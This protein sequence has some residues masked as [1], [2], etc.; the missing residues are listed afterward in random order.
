MRLAGENCCQQFVGYERKW[1]LQQ[2]CKNDE[3][4][5]M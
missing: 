5:M 1:H 4:K 3:V 2:K